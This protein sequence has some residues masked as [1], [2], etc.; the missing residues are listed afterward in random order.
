MFSCVCEQNKRALCLDNKNVSLQ[1]QISRIL[2]KKR[3]NI[4]QVDSIQWK[5]KRL[6]RR[7]VFPLL[8]LTLPLLIP[9]HYFFPEGTAPCFLVTNV[10][11]VILVTHLRNWS[12]FSVLPVFFLPLIICMEKYIRDVIIL[13]IYP[14]IETNTQKTQFYDRRLRVG[15][16]SSICF[17]S[18]IKIDISNIFE[19]KL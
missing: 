1:Y 4:H 18:C 6:K 9:P 11:H 10:T 7:K 8:F 14:F 19:A 12:F 5:L 13:S 17:L 16:A 15:R 3:I 2:Y